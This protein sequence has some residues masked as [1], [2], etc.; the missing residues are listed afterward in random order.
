[1]E[2]SEVGSSWEALGKGLKYIACIFIKNY[3]RTSY[4][5]YYINR[6]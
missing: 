5:D 6:L 4:C 3:K 2:L 1:M